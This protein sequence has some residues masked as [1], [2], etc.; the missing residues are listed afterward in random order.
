MPTSRTRTRT[1]NHNPAAKLR[2]R[3]HFLDKYHCGEFFSVFDCCRGSGFLWKTLAK[4][5]EFSY[6][7][8]DREP[9]KGLITV[10]SA[11]LLEI[12]DLDA[13]VIDVDTYG[14]PWAHWLNLL[15]NVTRPVTVF[16]TYGLVRI[17]G[18][19]ID[20]RTVE[21]LGMS[22][23]TLEAPPALVIKTSATIPLRMV[24]LAWRHGLKV[25]EVAEAVNRGNARYFGVRL[26][27]GTGG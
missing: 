19:N 27:P 15:P 4:T 17:V 11:R 21:A 16:L 3:R 23:P 13:D 2:L 5:Y 7:G 25:V 1:D 14:S 12:A 10:D 20:R 9:G 18:G 6:F 8:V 26:E 24:A 22:F